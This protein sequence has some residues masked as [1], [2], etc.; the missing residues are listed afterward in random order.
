MKKLSL[1]V[2]VTIGMGFIVFLCYIT[3]FSTILFNL[4]SQSINESENLAYE[5]SSSSV[6]Q[7]T[8]EFK[9]LELISQ[10]LK[11]AVTK[12][13]DAGIQ[14]RDSVIEMEKE[15]LDVNPNIFAVTVAFEANSFDGKDHQYIGRL[16]SG[17]NGEFMPYVSRG[18]SSNSY[19]L[20]ESY[21]TQE[22]TSWYDN[23]KN[24]KDLY[25]SEP[26]TYNVDNK[27][28]QLVSISM[29][30]L[31]KN[32]DFLGVISLDYNLDTLNNIISEK[33]PLGGFVELISNK[34]VYVA[35]GQD[36]S[37]I[38]TNAKSNDENWANIIKETSQGKEVKTYGKSAIENKNILI[39]SMPVNLHNKNSDWVLCSEIPKETIL[40][41]Y[42][43]IFKIILEIAI[44]SLI[45]VNVVI[46]FISKKMIK[47]VEYADSQLNLL[48]K[49]DLTIE[50]NNSYL[51]MDNEI[52]R[53]FNSMNNLKQSYKNIIKNVQDECKAVLDSISNAN[54]KVQELN[55]EIADVSATTEE[56]SAGM[57]ETA[58]SVEEINSSSMEMGNRLDS[59]VSIIKDGKNTAKEIEKR[60]INLKS[61]SIQSQEKSNTIAA[62]LED[63]L[64]ISLEKSKAV[65]QINSLT[66]KI[67]EITSQTN[68]L[69]LNA[70]IESARAGEAGK[71]F[72]V[73]ADE[74]R[75]LA[76]TSKETAIKIQEIS[77]EVNDAVNSLKESSYDVIEFINT[78][79]INDYTK[80]VNTGEQYQEDSI[81]FN[82][83][84]TTIS[85]TSEELRNSTENI[86]AAIDGVSDATA[87]G[88]SG[89]SI[90]ATKSS[91]IVNLTELFVE[92]TQKSKDSISKLLE[93]VSMFKI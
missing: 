35:S 7:I 10:G 28:V 86:I 78:Q 17:V 39:V 24:S 32:K 83:L 40:S 51:K 41:G 50:F 12:Q 30:I 54:A 42:N 92:E 25:V 15:I 67:L 13:I 72:A 47:G 16:D 58:A 79:V 91:D 85:E 69:A 81:V 36:P 76:E 80:L 75:V 74:I 84:V 73:V 11:S 93:S 56:L 63:N 3:V 46:A 62:E 61:K 31:N 29:P 4:H 55:S 9:D 57:E 22:D 18:D 52:G 6:K 45:I 19:V 14:N 20:E 87:E 68:L 34:G 65:A 77:K 90:I 5:I 66:D 43:N 1:S 2:K 64:K 59:V 27:D 89:T 60:A 53:M 23:T 37:L 70:A 38:M 8:Q 71:G 44:V 21:S 82:K 26:A 48:S 33:K 88:A 49:G